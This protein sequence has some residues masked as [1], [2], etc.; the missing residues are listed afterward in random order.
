MS[1]AVR[2]NYIALKITRRLVSIFL[3]NKYGTSINPA[4]GTLAEV[5]W[6][7]LA[8]GTYIVTAKATDNVGAIAI[9]APISITVAGNQP[10]VVATPTVSTTTAYVGA[11]VAITANASDPDGAIAKVEFYSGAALIGTVNALAGSNAIFSWIPTSAGT[12]QITAKAFDN[13]GEQTVS[14]ALALTIVANSLPVVTVTAPAAGASFKAN[15]NLVLSAR[16]TDADGGNLQD[17]EF[18]VNGVSVGRSGA[19]PVGSLGSA[20]WKV[21]QPGTYQIVAKATDSV[22]AVSTSAP[23]TITATSLSATVATNQWQF[24]YDVNGNGTKATDPLNKITVGAY[25]ELNRMRQLTQ[26]NVSAG[27]PVIGMT[28]DAADQPASVTDPRGLITNYATSGLGD[29]TGLTSPDTGAQ[30]MTYDEVGNPKTSKDARGKTTT[31]V[32]DALDRV[33]SIAYPTGLATTF[34]YDGGATPAPFSKGRLTKI[35]DESGSTAY[36][37][38]IYGRVITKTQISGSGTA[39]RTSVIGYTYGTSGLGTNRMTAITYASGNRVN[40]IYD[41]AG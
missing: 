8:N 18:I 7:P 21:L 41:A 40:Y 4:A 2:F 22:G 33:K 30:V 15:T 28:Y 37:Y 12:Y 39:A 5:P 3:L 11:P 34:E 36:A 26:P 32:Y 23:V 1:T 24:E 27:T 35:T 25:D 17:I 38:D 13:G 6:T 19:V 16:A 29:N 31:Y 14:T 20:N 10:P 9:S